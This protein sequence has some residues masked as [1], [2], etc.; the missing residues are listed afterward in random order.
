MGRKGHSYGEA[1]QANDSSATVESTQ[2]KEPPKTTKNEA[3]SKLNPSEKRR[4]GLTR[5]EWIMAVLTLAGVTVAIFTGLIFKDQLHEMRTDQRAWMHITTTGVQYETDKSTGK[6]AVSF[7]IAIVNTGKTPATNIATVVV[8]EK[9]INGSWPDFIYEGRP[10]SH[11]TTG[12]AFPNVNES[13]FRAQL[14]QGIPNST[15][16]EPRLLSPSE[17]Q[18]IVDGNAYIVIYAMTTYTDV[19]GTQHWTRFC[20]FATA[21]TTKSF[22]LTAK[23]CTDYNNVDNN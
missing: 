5:F 17:Y 12:S 19:F 14:L 2:K 20:N 13:P 18:D 4:W 21:P 23:P 11:E 9:D 8:V 7:P 16:V 22:N 15:G 10:A 1:R 3:T 6:V